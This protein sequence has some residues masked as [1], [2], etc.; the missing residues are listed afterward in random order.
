M[1]LSSLMKQA[2]LDQFSIGST[3]WWNDVAS[4]GT[5]IRVPL[6]ADKTQLIFLW[7]ED[8]NKPKHHAIYL[9]I[10][11]I[12]N[13]HDFN[14]AELT[15]YEDTDVYY[16]IC[17]VENSWNG[18]YALIPV[19]LEAAQPVYCGGKE[20]QISQH[21]SWIMKRREHHVADPL[22]KLN[23]K[24]GKWGEMHSRIYLDPAVIHPA[25]EHF[26]SHNS[27]EDWSSQCRT[28]LYQSEILKHKRRFWTYSTAKETSTDLPLVI[29][30]DGEFWVESMPIMRAL[31]YCT[32]NDLLP[33][34]IYL[35]IDAISFKQRS[36]DLTCNPTFWQAVIEEMIPQV[37]EQF[38]VSI[39]SEKSVVAGQSYGGL[40]ALYAVLN[41]P[42]KFSNA[43]SQSGSFWWPEHSLMLNSHQADITQSLPETLYIDRDIESLEDQY[44][45]N[46]YMEVGERETMMI[47]LAERVH[48]KLIDNNHNTIIE[49]YD[50]GHDR[51]IWREGLIKGLIW[52]LGK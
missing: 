42:D 39:D 19:P 14:A 44:K 30:L 26:D 37:K 24:H 45:L 1:E 4:T 3:Q 31:D 22:N 36:E 25:W 48:N 8:E 33:P 18:T 47:P 15:R 29:L 32:Q 38:D 49:L 52:L 40:S 2:N 27:A 43:I 20:Q 23:F 34:A 9:D 11:G 50:G 12:I 46:V 21:R 51:L 28:H 10:N 6:G 13:H 16:Y 17:K 7:R 35:M 5:P 41:W